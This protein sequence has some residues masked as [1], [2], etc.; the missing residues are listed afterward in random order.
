M[1][2]GRNRPQAEDR[3]ATTGGVNAR[4]YLT[5]LV[6]CLSAAT[7]LLGQ[8]LVSGRVLSPA[9]VLL[10]DAVFG[11]TGYQ[12][13]EPSNR[14]LTD[15]AFA[16]EPW[17][18][19]ARRQLV[20]G[21]WPFLNPY[22]GL[23]VPLFGNFQSALLCPFN[24]PFLLTGSPRS[25]AF[26]AYLKLLTAGLGACY[27]ARLL[28]LRRR[29][30]VLCG[31]WYLLT[32]FVVL[33]LLYPLG[34]VAAVFPWLT[35]FAVRVVRAPSG[36]SVAALAVTTALAWAGG[37]PETTVHAAVGAVLFGLG[38][39][40]SS[41]SEQPPRLKHVAYLAA[42]LGLGT[43]VAMPLF[44]S[45]A[46]YFLES[47]ALVERGEGRSWRPIR[48]GVQTGLASAVTWIAPY[49]YGSYA[50]G[51][52]HIER[53]LGVENF[54]ETGSGYTS[55][56][57]AVLFVAGLLLWPRRRWVRTALVLSATGWLVGY[58]TYPLYDVVQSL[59]VIGLFQNQRLLLWPCLFA[60]LVGAELLQ[61][62]AWSR[63]RGWTRW[64]P[65]ALLTMTAVVGLAVSSVL[66][67][68]R[69]SI[70]RYVR[71]YTEE[72]VQEGRVDRHVAS[73]RAI[74]I[75]ERA[76]HRLPQHYFRTALFCLLVAGLYGAS[77][78]RRFRRPACVSLATMLLLDLVLFAR[79]QLPI[80]PRSHWFPML[81]SAAD[82]RVQEEAGRRTLFVGE[83]FP[84]NAA[85]VY[86]VADLR[87]Y[88]GVE[89]RGLVTLVR[90]LDPDARTSADALDGE[91]LFYHSWRHR[92]L[93]L[94]GVRYLAVPPDAAI[95]DPA[96]WQPDGRIGA[97]ARFKLTCEPD[98][99]L[100]FVP[101]TN[102]CT[103]RS[104]KDLLT[105]VKP[106]EPVLVSSRTE[107]DLAFSCSV[108]SEGVIILPRL[109]LPGWRMVEG[110]Q[111]GDIV[112]VRS[113]LLGV[114]VPAG[115]S[116]RIRLHY[117]PRLLPAA[118][119]VSLVATIVIVV[120]AV[121]GEPWDLGSQRVASRQDA[122]CTGNC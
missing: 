50:R 114:R 12:D 60:P 8:A 86:R 62:R 94:I 99:R 80:I 24:W 33:W 17:L 70:E 19:E 52:V 67:W 21:H 116:V 41:A 111:E 69:E 28:R 98:T 96:C 10:S 63:L 38:A 74:L 68:A 30:A 15:V 61:T 6:A 37:H 83:T 78:V 55:V 84:P 77:R 105:Q 1:R 103:I 85:T 43:L 20:Q 109:Y 5:A 92:L 88:D 75:T 81:P 2:A 59:P 51:D 14:L 65:L 76:V 31:V 72:L 56:V 71:A 93:A 79:P 34:S 57:G 58:K 44:C 118:F 66:P 115:G 102:L 108:P 54:N 36:R 26:A 53:A 104:W 25:F 48:T 7:G 117:R 47:H 119:A 42:G 46:D 107:H 22:A 95:P 16:F 27:L 90:M 23:Y 87:S 39:V 91:R 40:A 100:W 35:A 82:T 73:A 9:D 120:L 110:P 112:A 122:P 113:A 32:G 64:L 49:A 106:I 4:E 121:A 89:H 11:R 3:R 29:Y 97:L 45:F 18:I 101:A 13:F